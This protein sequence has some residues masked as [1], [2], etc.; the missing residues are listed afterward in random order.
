[1]PTLHASSHLTD[2]AVDWFAIKRS[3]QPDPTSNKFTC[4]DEATLLPVT[5]FCCNVHGS[6]IVCIWEATT[7]KHAVERTISK[8]TFSRMSLSLGTLVSVACGPS[9]C[10]GS[11]ED[12]N[13]KATIKGKHRQTQNQELPPLLLPAINVNRSQRLTWHRD[14]AWWCQ[15]SG[16]RSP[17]KPSGEAWKAATKLGTLSKPLCIFYVLRVQTWRRHV[18]PLRSLFLLHYRLSTFC[19]S[20][21]SRFPYRMAVSK[22]WSRRDDSGFKSSHVETIPWSAFTGK[23]WSEG[24]ADIMAD[25]SY[26]IFSQKEDISLPSVPPSAVPFAAP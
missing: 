3:Q 9:T 20:W 15:S 7:L 6:N 17:L 2:L 16:H 19:C 18:H 4:M 13:E 25:K 26:L 14:K 10:E 12:W 11:L 21:Q 22:V 8:Q 5:A 23:P 24:R 1:M